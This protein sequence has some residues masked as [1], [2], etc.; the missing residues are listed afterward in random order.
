M[1]KRLGAFLLALPLSAGAGLIG[2]ERNTASA[3]ESSSYRRG[4][5]GVGV[6]AE[7]VGENVSVKETITFDLRE[8]SSEGDYGSAQI[9]YRFTNTG[10]T[11]ETV[12]LFLPL[13]RA[14]ECE[15]QEAKYALR[16]D[17]EEI[18]VRRRYTYAGGS[19]I[20]LTGDLPCLSEEYKS[21]GFYRRDTLVTEYVFRTEGLDPEKCAGF[22]FEY[23]SN[24]MR[25][26]VAFPDRTYT[27]VKNGVGCAWIPVCGEEPVRVYA[28]G[29]PLAKYG[30]SVYKQTTKAPQKTEALPASVA[31]T[32]FYDFSMRNYSEENGISRA[33]WYNAF[34]T[35]MSAVSDEGAVGFSPEQFG[36]SSLMKWYEYS[37]TVPAGG[38]VV[39]TVTQPL[40]PDVDT[41]KGNRYDYGF[42]L[43]PARKWETYEGIEIRILTEYNLGASSLEFTREEDGYYLTRDVLPQC[44]LS[45]SVTERQTDGG[46][47]PYGITPALTTA[48]I[49]LGVLL[50]L[51][52]ASVTVVVVHSKRK[53]RR[54][55]QTS[56]GEVRQGKID[57]NVPHDPDE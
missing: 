57:L 51:A 26:R 18:S 43:S 35:A 19:A 46:Y 56:A 13:G 23:C 20:S 17:G 11:D 6:I 47:A 37:L 44:E 15:T 30:C 25:T 40:R 36:E 4:T 2:A 39:N 54:K 8:L 55:E 12:T 24:P 31:Q 28:V 9:S 42:L 1:H 34:V 3:D 29:E 7:E 45:F 22:D 49:L 53:R 38:S 27:S 50:L 16:A 52:G 32:C 48:L 5:D 21:D 33:D 10:E 41:R 14:A